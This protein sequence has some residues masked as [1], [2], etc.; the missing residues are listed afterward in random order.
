MPSGLQIK[1]SDSD[2][3]FFVSFYEEKVSRLKAAMDEMRSKTAD[4]H[5]ECL[6]AEAIL[7]VL[8]GKNDYHPFRNMSMQSDIKAS[9]MDAYPK[10]G[11]WWEKI[12]WC[13]QQKAKV[14]SAKEVTELIFEQQPLL[15][16]LP[17][18]AMKKNTGNIFSTLT[19]KFKDK[20]IYRVKI[21]AEY[22]YGFKEWFTEDG[23]NVLP[24]FR[25]DRP[26]IGE[27]GEEVEAEEPES[28][29]V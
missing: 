1:V 23:G 22:K 10:T 27:S 5:Q 18:E 16:H 3:P 15:R 4:L 2:S 28:D 9:N 25:N 24:S 7:A 20:E 17:D 12:K 14:L 26:V 21:G 6:E 8:K 29:L 11:S 13:M 19:N